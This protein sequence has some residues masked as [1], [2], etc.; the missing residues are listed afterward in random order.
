MRLCKERHGHTFA[1]LELWF[2]LEAQDNTNKIQNLATYN[3]THI[4]S[5]YLLV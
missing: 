3:Y 1:G 4:Q 5:R 2:E